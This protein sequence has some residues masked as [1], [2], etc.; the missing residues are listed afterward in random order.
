MAAT[1]RSACYRLFAL[2]GLRHLEMKSLPWSAVYLDDEFPRIVCDARWTKNRKTEAIPLPPE[3][4][5]ILR[6]QRLATGNGVLVWKQVPSLN[7]LNADMRRAGVP[8]RDARGRPAGFHSFRKSLNGMARQAGVDADTRRRMLRHADPRLTLGTYS[9]V[10]AAELAAAAR[11]LPR[12]GRK[13][14][15]TDHGRGSENLT[16]GAGTDEDGG[17]TSPIP[18]L[19]QPAAP[20]SCPGDVTI[21]EREFGAAGCCRTCP[22]AGTGGRSGEGGIRTPR[23]D[24]LC[25]PVLAGAPGA[26]NLAAALHAAIDAFVARLTAGTEV[27]DVGTDSSGPSGALGRL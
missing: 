20:G 24:R 6:E 23:T 7:T 25:P 15:S 11:M 9:D 26:A 17:V 1:R 3:A 12:L 10:Q 19:R 13:E 18:T 16:D 5:E 27:P 2:T 22:G 8:K 4:E 21:A 14:L